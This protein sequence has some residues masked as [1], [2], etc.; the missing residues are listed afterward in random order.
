MVDALYFILVAFISYFI[1]T[2]N[3]S[4][5]IAW[6]ARRKDITKVGSGNPGTMNMLR[7]FGFGLA[8]FTFLAE[9]A[10]A[11]LTCLVFK[12]IFKGYGELIYFEAGAFLLFGNIFPVWS[13]FKGGK[14]VA[15]FAGIF[16]FSNLWYVALGWFVLCFI[17]FIFVNYACIISFVYIGGLSIGYTIYLWLTPVPH[18]WAI[19][20]IIWMLYLLMLFMHR[21]NIMRLIKGTENKIDFKSKLREVFSHKKGEQIIAEEYIENKTPENEIVITEKEQ[22][23]T[24][25]QDKQAEQDKKTEQVSNPEEKTPQDEIKD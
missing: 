23:T 9:V 19:T 18:A 5:I 20:I 7:S 22:Q 13:G 3:F 12:L 15:C 6:N 10:K 1:G 21:G 2:I 24:S 17:L 11:G 16:L 8:L 4:K 25:E 14:G